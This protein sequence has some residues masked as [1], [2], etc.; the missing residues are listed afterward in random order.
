MVTT[1][2]SPRSFLLELPS[3]TDRQVQK[4]DSPDKP[5]SLN[6]EMLLFLLPLLWAGSLQKGPQ[7]QL[8]V[9]ESVTVQEGLCVLVPCEV[10][11]PRVGWDDSTPAYG[12]WFRKRD[13]PL[14][15]VLVATNN[16][17]SVAK[18]K[19][20]IA[21]YLSGHPG[22]NNCSL[23]ITDAQKQE[24]GKYYFRLMRGDNVRH[25]YTDNLLTVNV[26][27]L[28]WTPDIHAKE[29]LEAGS[30]THLTCSLPGA[31]DRATHPSI[32]WTGAA[33]HPPELASEAYKSSEILLTPRPQ[34]HGT[35]L[36]CR[37][38][39]PR[40]GVS[41]EGTLMLNVSYAPQNLSISVSRGNCTELKYLGNGSSLSVLE[42]ESLRLVCVADSNP[43]ATLSWARG[44]RTLSP[45]QPSNPGVLLLPRVDS[46]H[47]GKFTCRAQHPRGSLGIS[48]HLS[49]Q[50]EL[51]GGKTP[52]ERTLGSM[53]GR[54][55]LT[56]LPPPRRP[57]AAA[58]TLLLLGGPGS[59]L[60]LLLPIP[61]RP[62]PL[63]W[64]LG[65]GLLEGTISNASFKITSRSAGPW[66][67]SSLS[68][69]EGLSSGLSLSCEALNVHGA[70]SATVLLLP[71]QG[72]GWGQRLGGK[73]ISILEKMTLGRKGAWMGGRK[74]QLWGGFVLGA[75]E[76]AGIAGLL[77][78]CSCFILFMVKTFRKEAPGVAAEENAP[79]TS[80]G[81]QY[82]CLPGSTMDHPHPVEEEQELHYAS[83]SFPGLRP[84]EPQD[85]EATSATEYTE[86]KICK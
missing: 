59:A 18:K 82:E 12:Y 77:S 3:G 17:L 36:T 70:Q 46:D 16:P 58:G 66:A 61:A 83:L 68:L 53:E 1:P 9:Q 5:R 64:R 72:A 55:T 45:S 51:G 14:A 48:L 24:S 38:T 29:P 21:F 67:N 35:N 20:N 47:E 40:A 84:R 32:S 30:S 25:S 86:L 39:F 49:V 75:V 23:S 56:F 13:K 57:P 60:Q 33:L 10:S 73:G 34:D 22:A 15:D 43:P 19:T 28:S 79:S 26:T 85:Q 54:G 2:F 42:G 37:V 52:R 50:S 71:G 81:H 4:P 7:Y 41:S 62:L 74:P 11:Y 8:R 27:A 80:Q 31:C 78:L 76:G 69:S 44:S 63:R 6:V 65:E